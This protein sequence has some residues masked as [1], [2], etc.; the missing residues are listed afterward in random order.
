MREL[1]KQVQAHVPFR[2]L[3]T[4]HLDLVISEGINPEISFNCHDLENMAQFDYLA[5]AKRLREA[6]RTVTF[7]APFM[8]LRPGAIDPKIRQITKDRLRQVL[9]MAFY[10]HP[11]TVVCHASF[12]ERYY[13]SGKQAWL[14]NSLE[15]WNYF[16]PLAEEI[17]TVIVLENVYETGPDILADLLNRLQSPRIRFCFDV[18]HFNVFSQT[19][20]ETWLEKMASHL[21][22]LHIHDNNGLADDHAPVGEGN[23]PFTNFFAL[24][25]ERNLSPLITLEAHSLTGLWKTIENIGT[26][27]LLEKRH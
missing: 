2:L 18:G 11:L 9:D 22:Q 17:K 10:F 1:I 8:D 3:T 5:I 21:H 15:T 6:E 26:L 12:D 19:P 16:L 7:H 25:R 14:D 20:I 24:L 27:A 23:F 4:E 13:V